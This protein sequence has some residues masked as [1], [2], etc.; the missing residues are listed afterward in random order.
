MFS[1]QNK[2]KAHFIDQN[3]SYLQWCIAMLSPSKGMDLIA[4]RLI[5]MLLNVS[6]LKKQINCI[7]ANAL[8]KKANKHCNA[9]T[10]IQNMYA[11]DILQ[12]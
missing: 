2:M 4:L 8:R 3:R 1:F 5:R 12:Q 9:L 10:H 7:C 11:S 6:N